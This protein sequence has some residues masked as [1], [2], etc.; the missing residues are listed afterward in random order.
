[1]AFNAISMLNY[2]YK[3]I[4]EPF[5][6]SLYV[7]HKYNIRSYSWSEI[8]SIKLDNNSLSNAWVNKILEARDSLEY[9]N[10]YMTNFKLESKIDFARQDAENKN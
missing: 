2:L 6:L 10:I 8:Q 3:K 1:M 4:V 7:L 5:P 9:L